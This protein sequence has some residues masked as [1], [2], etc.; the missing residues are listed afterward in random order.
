MRPSIAFHSIL[1][2][3]ISTA[4]C[5]ADDD[6]VPAGTSTTDASTS[7]PSTSGVTDDPAT[8]EAPTSNASEGTDAGESSGGSSEGSSTSTTG[9]AES[10]GGDE[11]SSAGETGPI[12]C[13]ACVADATIGACADAQTMCDQD[14]YCG[15]VAGCC[16]SNPAECE[17]GGCSCADFPGSAANWAG[18]VECLAEECAGCEPAACG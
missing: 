1:A 13:E 9:P 6:S 4:S 7:S 14:V 17:M 10:S 12:D 18:V 5:T 16:I 15:L 2:F 11:S 3:A 8:T